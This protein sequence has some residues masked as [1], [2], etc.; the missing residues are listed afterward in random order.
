MNFD[1]YCD[2]SRQEYF[3]AQPHNGSVAPYCKVG[4]LGRWRR[5]PGNQFT[6]DYYGAMC[7][8]VS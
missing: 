2:E 7:P 6:S 1:I 5:R 3:A 4:W 8:G